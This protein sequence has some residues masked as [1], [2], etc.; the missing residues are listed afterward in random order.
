[1]A[2]VFPALSST[3]DS[4]F[5]R[6]AKVNSRGHNL[7]LCAAVGPPNF[8]L[9]LDAERFQGAEERSSSL[10]DG[11]ETVRRFKETYWRLETCSA[12]TP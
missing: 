9:A 1:M 7:I 12:T 2:Q 5:S 11:P 3:V 10:T 8:P 4:T 6:L